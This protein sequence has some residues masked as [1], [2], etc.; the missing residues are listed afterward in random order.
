METRPDD[1]NA[2][3]DGPGPVAPMSQADL[4]ALILQ[5]LLEA[6]PGKCAMV[7]SRQVPQGLAG[8]ASETLV[9]DAQLDSID[10]IQAR[11]SRG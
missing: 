4:L 5:R 1:G 8:I 3:G 11:A 10:P 7:E 2:A 6:M 9:C